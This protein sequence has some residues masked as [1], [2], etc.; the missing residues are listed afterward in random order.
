MNITEAKELLVNCIR[1]EKDIVKI[2]AD[3]V[4]NFLRFIELNE[5]VLTPLLSISPNHNIYCSWRKNNCVFS[6]NFLSNN[7]I[8]YVF[9]KPN[10]VQPENKIRNYG[11]SINNTLFDDVSYDVLIGLVVE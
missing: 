2:S 5:R 3:S 1:R 11:T 7:I 6:I 8:R 10:L 9:S 4:N